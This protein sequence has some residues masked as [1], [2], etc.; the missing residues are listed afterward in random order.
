MTASESFTPTWVHGLPA[1]L[2]AREGKTVAVI[3]LMS[4]AGL[5]RA[6]RK[7]LEARFGQRGDAPASLRG[8]SRTDW[9]V[10]A[11]YMSG[12]F[13]FYSF[14]VVASA[15]KDFIGKERYAHAVEVQLL[16]AYDDA[17][18]AQTFDE[19]ALIAVCPQWAQIRK[20]IVSSPNI[21]AG[22]LPL[23]VFMLW[24]RLLDEL[25]AW[26][27]LEAPRQAQV[28]HAVFA[29]STI[30][31]T[32]WF[33][34]EAIRRCPPLEADL[35]SQAR[36]GAMPLAAHG[37][38]GDASGTDAD[39]G[40]G[41]STAEASLV[42]WQ[43]HLDRLVALVNDLARAPTREGVEELVAL[44][45]A[46]E[47]DRDALPSRHRSAADAL[48]QCQE[49]LMAFLRG[50]A[51]QDL[52]AWLEADVLQRI[53]AQW[54]HAMA[55]ADEPASE[56]LMADAGAVLARSQAAADAC[57]SAASEVTAA[58]AA[59]ASLEAELAAAQGFTEKSAIRRRQHDAKKHEIDAEGVQHARQD[60]L[61]AAALPLGSALEPAALDEAATD[62]AAAAL[63]TVPTT[64]GIT[65]DPQGRVPAVEAHP[66]H[67][68][69][70]AV[71]EPSDVDTTMEAVSVPE[72]AA[73][74]EA[75]T[76]L[77]PAADDLAPMTPA[78]AV[79]DAPDD[80]AA[81]VWNCLAQDEP[82]LAYHAARWLGEARPTV[83]VP[84]PD[85]LAA[86]ALADDLMNPDGAVQSAL[87]ARYEQLDED[88]F[89]RDAASP[90]HVAA[91]LLLIA[92]TLRPMVLAPSSG[93]VS[94]ADYL[95]L[96]G[97]YVALYTLVN[98]LREISAKLVGFRIDPTVLRHARGEAATRAEL[99]LLQRT[100]Q[101]WL[102]TQ[103]PAF[104][105]RYAP[106]TAVWKQ[107]LRPEGLIE[108][109]VSPVIHN[110]IQDAGRVR[111]TLAMLADEL[112]IQRLVHETDRKAVR[113]RHGNN[114]HASALVHLVRLVDEA[115]TLPRQWLALV[116]LLGGGGNR[117]RSLLEDVHAAVR[118]GREAVERELARIPT[119]DH[120]GM[121]AAGQKQ[122]LKALQGLGALFD[123]A[124]PVRDTERSPAEALGRGC[125]LV[126]A[127]GISEVYQVEASAPVA[128][129][130][131]AA[132]SDGLSAPM[133]QRERM[134]RGDW[135]G[136]QM[137]VDT[138]LL[139][140]DLIP[141]RQER[142]RWKVALRR[143]L[144]A[145]REVVEIGSA[146]GYL[147]DA[148]RTRIEGELAREEAHVEEE[149]RFDVALAA[150]K[151][152]QTQVEQ[153]RE[154]RKLAVRAA[155]SE[156]V[157]TDDLRAGAAD[158]EQALDEGDIATAHEL[159]HWLQQGQ[160]MPTDAQD[161]ACEGFTN[162]FP[163]SMRALEAWLDGKKPEAVQ[164]AFGQGAQVPGIDGPRL[165]SAQ[166]FQAANMFTSWSELKGR[167]E[168]EAGR[169]QVL[170]EGLGLPVRALAPV[171]TE[172]VSGREVWTLET[173][174]VDDRHICP[175][176]MF[177]SAAAG[178]YRVI[179]VWG[180]PTEDELLQWVGDPSMSRPTLLLYFGRMTERKWRDLG[181]MAKV[182]RRSFLFLDETLL[183]YL[184]GASGLRLRAWFD[185]ALPFAYSSPYDPTA[186]LVPPEMFYGRSAELE[187]VRGSN[188]R[189]FIYGGRQLG[190]TALLKRAEQSFHKPDSGHY[191]RWIDLRA[192]G[193]GVS[194]A[195]GEIWVTLHE[196]F[197][198]MGIIDAKVPAPTP[199][200]R[201]G[202]DRVVKAVREFL[203]ENPDRRVL[204]L[205]DE[206]DRFFEQDGQRDFE[207]TR[208]LKQLMDETQR[209]F[210]VV[211]AGLHNV[212]RMTGWANHEW[213]N[214]PLAHFGEPI[215]IGP[216]REGAEVDE[217]IDLVRRPMEAAGFR[218]EARGLIIRILAQTNYYPSL[219]QLYCSHLLRHMLKKVSNARADQHVTGPRYVITG[220][221]IELVY[222][223]DALREEIRAKFRLTLQLDPRYEVLAYAMALSLLR[224]DYTQVDGMPWQAIR[225]Q[226]AR[227][228]WADGFN[229][230]S[231]AEF[232][233]LLDEMKGLGVLGRPQDGRY[234]LRSANVL[235]LLGTQDEIETVLEK[236]REPAVEF[237]SV[238]FRPPMRS[239]PESP[240]RNIFT[241]QQLTQL[242][243]RQN[244][245]T[246]VTGNEA[247]GIDAVG[248]NLRDYLN[249]GELPVV[250]AECTDRASFG[251]R[252]QA[253]LAERVKDEVSVFVVSESM[254]WTDLWLKEAQTRL[255][256]LRSANRFASVVF[257]AEPATLWRL[258]RDGE[259]AMGD[260]FPWMSLHHWN[261]RFL[262]HW[263]GE[264]QL[265]LEPEERAVLADITG[266]WPALIA[267]RAGDRPGLRVLRDR[268]E[269]GV[270][271]P[272]SAE[273]A[274]AWRHK[275]GLDV[276][277]PTVVLTQLARWNEPLSAE[278]LAELSEDAVAHVNLCLRWADLLGLARRD[279]AGYWMVD[280]VAAR[281]LVALDR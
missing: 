80:G 7:T 91:N 218:F 94:V 158:V 113:R 89:A 19:D 279:G 161:D 54:A 166:R 257:V 187:A 256:G 99:E 111:D 197:R 188:G 186:G 39:M 123:S 169:L 5:N 248:A 156:L 281:V 44:A 84:S 280:P 202:W 168:G 31:R 237:E 190:K 231:E 18:L 4:R 254:P 141:L 167:R 176:P 41:V 53:E 132:A 220:K 213:A 238:S 23:G 214:H 69:S 276:A 272:D 52:F 258:L 164:Q 246:V 253:S 51:A 56:R 247:A 40:A 22:A 115:L 20:G 173:V 208:R 274:L 13:R 225:E 275:L 210:K 234:V 205:L 217:A 215:E 133:A 150:I 65:A 110:R 206:A 43:T 199:G 171:P 198:D 207:E 147:Q 97:Q 137:M 216:L 269:A 8:L 26:E 170:L 126:P 159:L 195:S 259:G 61:I 14:W 10:V 163:A 90:S 146:Y 74:Y 36:S 273:M 29:L 135:L 134:D 64:P 239:V 145:C 244:F 67:G 151:R 144:A 24:P 76:G 15:L 57:V 114:I 180:R 119:H 194:L 98:R 270:A 211:F 152:V 228:W 232:R 112:H 212:L 235:L 109:L 124:V 178:R 262:R 128:L 154:D 120:L 265:P 182:K 72:P 140:D 131:L 55:E 116:D 174:P 130:A 38:T 30:G 78:E 122:V 203:M 60:Q 100:A 184:C 179:C 241:Y 177:G 59:C 142:E 6:R 125:L 71:D 37:I 230:T 236:E 79:P 185:A 160:P 200:K 229:D 87:V 271:W 25:A 27:G 240:G 278:D 47:A 21:R 95:H 46:L 104:T 62:D 83:Q 82:G 192:E 251:T 102:T 148:D 243:Q 73:P 263:L 138:G 255:N 70:E 129:G 50:L 264:C 45:A 252:L 201:Q 261:D 277:E 77:S 11:N 86:A 153:G 9:H 139:D 3:V 175:V 117:L 66:E 181:R 88:A 34:D 58:K 68:T 155:L 17:W 165:A 42:S 157:I 267:E 108:A 127:L 101:D 183:A 172:T 107:W 245:I 121:V 16:Q 242:L 28:A 48:A 189:C 223:S 106:A 92:A 118:N 105:I 143:E 149:R 162:F 2:M 268:L 81:V 103:A 49:D 221:D 1:S 33:I 226:C 191:A 63:A 75:A 136:A 96:D 219:I 250:M 209:R 196:R 12:K 193:I 260:E 204:L 233:L 222:S 93:A 35:G 249:N 266:C 224:G 227:R 85:L 32:P